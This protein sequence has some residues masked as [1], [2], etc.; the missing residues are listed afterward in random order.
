MR[1]ALIVGIDYYQSSPLY[2]CVNDAHSMN[3]VLSRHG[4]RMINF[5]CKL[6][7]AT[8][9]HDAITR[10]EIKDAVTELFSQQVEVALF[11]FAGHGHVESTGGYLCASDALRGDDGLSLNDILTIAN[12]SKASNKIIILDSCHS[13]IAGD[14]PT[15]PD[16]A[17]LS[18]G[19]TI[20]TASTKEQ[21]ASEDNGHGVFTSL[22]IDALS[23]GAANIM[24]EITPGSIYAHID[25]A[26][27]AWEQRPV[28]KS[29][30]KNFISLR[31][32]EPL[33]SLTDLRKIDHYFPT[34]GYTFNLNP[35]FEPNENGKSEG[36]D[37]GDPDNTDIFAVLQK[38]NRLGLLV[39]ND[40]EHMWNAAIES[41]SCSL[42]AL[43][44]HYRKLAAKE[45][46]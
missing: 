38:Y 26:L 22:L 13:G 16:V 29:N 39:P 6:M 15:V 5:E 20:L 34:P 33:I 14:I 2:G 27:G 11:Y 3:S 30:V 7:T 21:Y 45:R 35:S 46:F 8:S 12:G 25:Q 32:I 18:E 43:G 28:F 40:S 31:K 17:L 41:K 1:K 10:G 24:G 37:K 23:G 44:E 42:T 19:T 9:S 4:N 36:M